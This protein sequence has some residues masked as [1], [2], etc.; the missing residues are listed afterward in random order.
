MAERGVGLLV[1]AVTPT[2]QTMSQPLY[3]PW[4]GT[5]SGPER[6]VATTFLME[7]NAPSAQDRH[8]ANERRLEDERCW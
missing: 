3:V 4:V 1:D 7:A 8:G 5:V 2:Q 6:A